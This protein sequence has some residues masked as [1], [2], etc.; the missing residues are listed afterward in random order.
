MSNA[1]ASPLESQP[2]Q[3]LWLPEDYWKANP[4]IDDDF[5]WD[6]EQLAGTEH[7]PDNSMPRPLRAFSD[8]PFLFLLGRPGSGK[9][10]EL[11]Q[12]RKQ[13]RLGSHCH[14]IEGKEF[15]GD[16]AATLDRLV[17]GATGPA[18][19]CIDGLDEVL[20]EHPNFVPQLKRW[21]LGHLGPD[22]EPVF[23]LAITCRWADWPVQ[24]VHELASL[25]QADR[26]AYLMLCP[27]R[28]SDAE[29]T[30]RQQFGS[31]AD[32][33][34]SQMRDH[35]LRPVACWP[36]G[37]LGLR[38]QFSKSGRKTI[39]AGYSQ[40]IADQISIHCRLTDSPDDS[41]RW[42]A[43]LKLDEDWCRRL[44]G[45][46]AAAMIWSGRSRLTLR[47]SSASAEG[48]TASDFKDHTELWQGSL[49]PVQTKDL[50]DL[51][52]K[53]RLFRKLLDDAAWV[54]A[55]QVHQEFL[56]AEW[57][58]AQNLD[59]P[60]L[61][62]LFGR[63]DDGRWRVQPALGAVAAWLA[64]RNKPFRQIVIKH[65][66]LVLLRMDGARIAE[67][68]R[69]EVVEALLEAT[70]QIGVLDP[71]IR[72]A[73]LASLAHMGLHA[74][75]DRWLRRQD[76]CAATKE[77]AI[78]I[79]EKA[80]LKSLA[81]VLWELYPKATGRVQ[82]EMAGAL[83]RLANTSEYDTLW[84]S[85]LRGEMPGD[86]H[87][88]LLGAAI[89]LQIL[90]GKRP[91]AD[92]LEWLVPARHFDV[93]GLFDS[94]VRILPEKLTLDD[95]PAVFAK[96]AEF[97]ELIRDTLE[98]PHHLHKAAV[99]LAIA[100]F[101]RSKIAQVLC[102]YW[103]QCLAR[104]VSPH[105]EL[106]S[107]W[108][109]EELGVQDDSIRRSI[110]RGLI[111]H[112]RFA[113]HT[114]KKWFWTDEYMVTDDD[115][116]WGLSE[117]FQS[118]PENRWRWGLMLTS[119]LWRTDLSGERGS[120]L[121]EAWTTMPEIRSFLPEPAH[122]ESMSATIT[123]LSQERRLSRDSEK[124]RW[125][126]K[127]EERDAKFKLDLDRYT[128]SCR[129]AHE[130]G[131][132]TWGGVSRILSARKN[133]P[134]PSMVT[135]EPI[136]KIGP[137][138]GWMIESAARY[139]QELPETRP[140]ELSDGIGGLLALA[141]CLPLVS[142][143]AGLRE[144]IGRHWLAPMLA[145]FSMSSLGKVPDGIGL[146]RFADWFPGR[147]PDALETVI[148]QRYLNKGQ[149]GELSSFRSC[150][151]EACDLKLAKLLRDEP[152]QVEG[153]FNAMRMLVE[154]NESLAVDALRFWLNKE[155]LET[156]N[157][158]QKAAL[159]GAGL[160]LLNGRCVEDVFRAGF[161][162]DE[163]ARD[164]IWRSVLM[165]D[166]HERRI[167]FSNWSDSSLQQV[168]ELCGQAYTRV[169]RHRTNGQGFRKVTGEDEAIDFRDRIIG[170]ASQRGIYLDLPVTVDQDTPEEAVSRLHTVNWHRNEATRARLKASRDLLP[171][172]SLFRL[173]STP[174]ARLARDADELMA[175]VVA[176]V[177]RWEQSLR[178]GKWTHL[179][180]LKPLRA[181]G[182]E[183]IAKELRDW[184]HTDLSIVSE[185]EVELRSERR[186]D[187]MVQTLTQ[188]GQKLTVLI[189]LKKVRKD[190]TNAKERR[191]AMQTQLR[192]TYLTQRLNE[193]WTHGL[194]IVAW[195]PEPGHK[196]DSNEAMQAEAEF[197]EKQAADLSKSPF[198]LAGMV[199]DARAVKKVEKVKKSRARG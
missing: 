6:H 133:G 33:F 34:G 124:A 7:M 64:G 61:K 158:D 75:L 199:V 20:L 111:L 138:D 100:H 177:Q 8:V 87:G 155:K 159:A 15:G 49:K 42:A 25:W 183:D 26:S 74:Q 63:E 167:D 23:R 118:S 62:Q 121:N 137:D 191:T 52:R 32:S 21:L 170:E 12:A 157:H 27:L 56:A 151:S 68:E 126:A 115:F 79:A 18:R 54:F 109:A 169:D 51:V 46:L 67:S 175:A 187:V 141:A 2:W 82:I 145:D 30:I 154:G 19:L 128:Q 123:R 16:I 152:V 14:W 86:A 76:V 165:L 11:D 36:Q 50:D 125:Q 180:D 186:T 99:K 69:S 85:V 173:C 168:A 106:N 108:N 98:T 88:S 153:F 102:D 142:E 101:E 13:G 190:K 95:L 113:A 57:L 81:P 179:W 110:I 184:L 189:E 73:H 60:R 44:A 116:D 90:S 182:E 198:V 107:G 65:D 96:L 114:E 78:E 97:P 195:T 117:L 120:R 197:L 29:A 71:A 35:H 58:S 5:L 161:L 84:Q 188:W 160:L 91:V 149:L 174:H 17:A 10:W 122:G 147:L 193:G 181:R 134:G 172:A 89:E 1:I 135:F 45:R 140:L 94:V 24:S 66:P 178:N 131:Q 171:P 48:L 22:G 37:L 139:L 28:W 55:S 156:L 162:D 163:I 130:R 59:E 144:A 9:S 129:H 150:W 3:R 112:P 194:F 39:C 136:S 164:A 80:K 196:L 176:S 166:F 104:N 72:Q 70:E 41:G 31:D 53:T 93:Y 38:E 192:D 143:D 83:Y 105:K 103:H 146:E 77:L 92:A 185:R 132:L 119:S 43:A 4:G 127:H 47:L 148:R 40:A